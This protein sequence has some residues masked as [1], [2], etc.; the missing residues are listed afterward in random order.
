VRP[1]VHE[2]RRKERPPVRV[3][4]E[5]GDIMIRDL[6]LWHVGMSNPTEKH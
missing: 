4:A 5:R 3:L 6:R 2:E 1:D